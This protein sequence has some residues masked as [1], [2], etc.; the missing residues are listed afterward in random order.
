M[1][2]D[3]NHMAARD[4]V[5]LLASRGRYSFTSGEACQTLDV[6][7]AAGKQ[8]LHRLTVQGKIASP[9]RGFY[10][11]VPPEYRSLNCLP[12]EQFIPDLAEQKG[13]TYYAGLLTAAQYHGAAHQRP[14]AFQ[15]FLQKSRR[16]IHCG[17]VKVEFI[18]KKNV[19]DIPICKRNTARGELIIS[20]PEATAIDLT[21]YPEH[22]GG[23]DQ[24]TTI[25][26]ELADE[27]DS[28]ALA[29]AAVAAPVTWAQRLGY[30]LEF[31]GKQDIAF[32]IREYVRKHAKE[33]TKLMPGKENRDGQHL[34]DW[35]L[36]VNT[37]LEP[38]L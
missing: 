16:P 30:I 38:D 31:L 5:D 13:L 29:K 17:K 36:I 7:P 2:S 21:G 28:L 10:V 25:V 15:V 35:K 34:R 32:D 26:A 8:A 20:T 1:K 6:S 12:A 27:I 11:I 3:K 33:Y 18:A 14:Q 19:D 9:A 37:I 4:L 24:I 23:L 22:A